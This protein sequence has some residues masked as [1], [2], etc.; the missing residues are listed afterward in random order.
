MNLKVIKNMRQ[1]K[2][3]RARRHERKNVMDIETNI[4]TFACWP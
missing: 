4:T 3:T 1:A 2:H